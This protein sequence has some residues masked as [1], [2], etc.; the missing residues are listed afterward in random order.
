MSNNDFLGAVVDPFVLAW[1]YGRLFMTSENTLT[2]LRSVH[3]FFSTDL[4]IPLFNTYF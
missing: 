4:L 1:V 3:K 2:I